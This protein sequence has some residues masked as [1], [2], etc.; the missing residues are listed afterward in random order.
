MRR[1]YGAAVA[2]TAGCRVHERTLVSAHEL[3][4]AAQP[5][6][7]ALAVGTRLPATRPTPA[8]R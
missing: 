2:G 8:S 4:S 5:A 1:A 7:A 3:T 6:K